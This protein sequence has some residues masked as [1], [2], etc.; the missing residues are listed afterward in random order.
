MLTRAQVRVLRMRQTAIFMAEAVFG[1]GATLAALRRRGL[2]KGRQ[3][4][5]EL[6]PLGERVCRRLDRL[7]EPDNATS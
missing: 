1:H 7:Q 4:H 2:I 6:T 3:P 5:A